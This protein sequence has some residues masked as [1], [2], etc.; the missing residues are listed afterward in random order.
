ML[1]RA[2]LVALF[3]YARVCVSVCVRILI[4]L[5]MLARALLLIFFGYVHV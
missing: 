4:E 5:S 1:A 2:L 3:R